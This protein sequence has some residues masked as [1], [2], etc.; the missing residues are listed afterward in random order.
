MPARSRPSAGSLATARA[1]RLGAGAAA[2]SAV[3]R[4]GV[5]LLRRRSGGAL[6]A[7][8]TAGFHV[9]RLRMHGFDPR[10]RAMFDNRIDRRRIRIVLDR[11]VRL[12]PVV[13]EEALC[14]QRCD[15]ERKRQPVEQFD[16]FAI[17]AV[18]L[19]VVVA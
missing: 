12:E 3:R 9:F 4:R 8:R 2:E 13:I 7:V 5:W 6:L 14:C 16:A 11:S 19:E 1:L 17:H 10:G 18:R 15:I